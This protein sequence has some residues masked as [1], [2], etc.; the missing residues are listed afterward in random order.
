MIKD[1]PLVDKH[2]IRDA[3]GISP[4]TLKKWRL[5][6]PGYPPCLTEGIH[7]IRVG[8]RDVRYN[9]SLIHDYLV[10]QHAPELHQQAI[11]HYLGQ[12]PSS[13][14]KRLRRQMP[15]AS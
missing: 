8:T 12:L 7:W 15:W 6:R 2:G 14:R 4:E 9:L 5:G 11:E 13:Q 1:Y 3:L 10:N